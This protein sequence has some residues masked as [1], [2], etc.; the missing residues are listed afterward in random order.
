MAVKPVYACVC[1]CA[2]FGAADPQINLEDW[3]KILQLL[4][5]CL[6]SIVAVPVILSACTSTS[7]V[8]WT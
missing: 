1:V 6:P 8:E 7:G 3:Y 5:I 2:Y 4:S